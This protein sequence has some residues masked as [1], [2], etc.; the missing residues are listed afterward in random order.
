MMNYRE[1]FQKTIDEFLKKPIEMPTP[2][3]ARDHL[4]ACGILN[5]DGTIAE[6]YREIVV[7]RGVI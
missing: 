1:R 5:D 6:Q 7:R 3:E 2:D 4:I